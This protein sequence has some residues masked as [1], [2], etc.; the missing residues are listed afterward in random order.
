MSK[1]VP[2][3]QRS[4]LPQGN[5]RIADIKGVDIDMLLPGSIA[6]AVQLIP[7]IVADDG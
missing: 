2:Q 4:I 7:G 5:A 3:L 1:V 6:I